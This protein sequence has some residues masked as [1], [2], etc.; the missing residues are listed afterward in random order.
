MKLGKAFLAAGVALAVALALVGCS[1]E[2]LEGGTHSVSF[3]VAEW[4]SSYWDYKASV[5]IDDEWKGN[6]VFDD[7]E[8]TVPDV[9]AGVHNV[10]I[11]IYDENGDLWNHGDINCDLTADATFVFTLK[12][13]GEWDFH[14]ESGCP[15]R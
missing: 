12:G 15:L 4:D 6:L 9:S 1:V 10:K 8:F 13:S 14:A 5:Y 2:I 7:V 3:K 11:E